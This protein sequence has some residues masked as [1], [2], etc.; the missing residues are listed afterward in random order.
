M[1]IPSRKRTLNPSRPPAASAAQHPV[2]WTVVS[3]DGWQLPIAAGPGGLRYVG[4]Q[5]Q[6][7]SDL[8][9]WA[10][11][12]YPASPFIRDDERMRPYARQLLEYLRGERTAFDL[13]LDVQGTPFQRAVW[14]ALRSVSY[15]STRSYSDI[16]EAVGKPSAVRAVGAA[17]GANP[18]LIA[19]PCHR[20]VGKNGALTGFR[21]GLEMKR[22]LLEMELGEADAPVKVR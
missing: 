19:I 3:C 4:G 13:P 2:Y 7:V 11:A 10:A 1:S 17:I 5:N 6:S 18:V 15:G 8:A 12:R 21:G 22:K 9:E 14:E 16:A 20:I